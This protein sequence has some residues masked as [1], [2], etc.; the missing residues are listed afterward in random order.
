[1]VT[2]VDADYLVVG[3]GAAGMAFA[4]ALTGHAE[5]SVALVDRRAAAGGHWLDAYPFVRLHQA[6][7]FYG[8]ASTLLGGGRRQASGP[9]AGLHERA[10]GTQIV[11]YYTG[12][13]ARLEATGRA[14]LYGGCDYRGAGRFASLDGTAEYVV[15]PG[16]RIVDARYLSPEI[17]ATTPP[18]FAVGDGARVIPVGELPDAGSAPRYVVAGSGKT[19]TDTVVW[20][21]RHGVAADAVDWIRPREPWMFNRAA[22]QPDPAVFLATAAATMEA[23]AGASSVD[24]MFLRLEAA[25]VLLRIDRSI[26]PTMAKTPTLATWELDLLRNVRHVIRLG[27]ITGVERGRVACTEGDLAVPADTLVAHCA[28]P[29]LRYPPPVPIWRPEVVTIQ[30]VRAGFPCFCAALIGYVEATRDDDAE[31][32]R[33]CP[34]TPY[35]DTLEQWARMQVLGARATAAFNAEPDV[36]AWADTVALNPARTPA[37]ELARP[38]VAAA[39]ARL[40]AASAEGTARLTVFGRVPSHSGG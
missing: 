21:L 23:A 10:T 11:A 28:A 30:N 35:S 34:P 5:V 12:V 33:L 8:V 38:E 26:A 14:R 22:I 7:A 16:C 6:S 32:N 2:V 19:A 1:M 17:P 13:L 4:D 40:Q 36:K 39:L 29:G 25:G 20:L 15:R 27:H 24:D 3:A 37:V 18:P 9:E 31:K